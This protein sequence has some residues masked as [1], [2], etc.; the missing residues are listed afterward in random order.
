MISGRDRKNI[1]NFLHELGSIHSGYPNPFLTYV[2]IKKQNKCAILQARVF[3]DTVKNVDLLPRLETK[4]FVAAQYPISALKKNIGEIVDQIIRGSLD[5]PDGKLH[6]L[7]DAKGRRP[8]VFY[9]LHPAGQSSQSKLTMLSF[10]G[11]APINP[12]NQTD[13][14]WE[15][16]GAET[17]YDSLQEL[18]FSY[19]LD[20]TRKEASIVELVVFN[21]VAMDA[22]SSVNGMVANLVVRLAKNLDRQSVSLG[23]RIFNQ[24]KVIARNRLSGGALQWSESEE[25]QTGTISVEVPQAS[26]LHCFPS[27][28]SNV[29]QHWWVVDQDNSQNPRRAIFEAF[30]SKLDTLNDFITK[31]QGRGRDARDLEVGASWLFWMLGFSV[32]NL[33]GTQRTQE[34][35]DL[36]ITSP[37][38][39]VAVVECTT[40]LLK[41]DNKLPLLL[42]RTETVKARLQ[43]SNNQHLK[44]MPIM[45][46]S[47]TRLEIRAD[48]EQAERLGILVVAAEDLA[49]LMT[50]TPVLPD[51]DQIFLQAEEE[52]RAAQEKQ[53]QLTQPEPK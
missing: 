28:L 37:A 3:F 16:R 53:L 52:T 23:Y 41:T 4:N 17:P 15:L 26:V 10:V 33:G 43:S 35:P 18:L 9:P 32:S 11:G 21:V 8:A 2:A 30:D 22:I 50:R 42:A 31:A 49:Q 25:F 13:F 38:G 5:T 1:S 24:G 51:A 47:K 45:I 36:L 27:Y 6:F 7:A 40:G 14:D 12:A 19:R 20:A 48:L 46:T 39:H 34:A 44:V 29:Q